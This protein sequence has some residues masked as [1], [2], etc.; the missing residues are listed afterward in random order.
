MVKYT[1][2]FTFLLKIIFQVL[3]LF[4]LIIVFYP[5]FLLVALTFQLSTSA[6]STGIAATLTTSVV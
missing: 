4:F 5:T 2:F 1:D 3:V 6:D